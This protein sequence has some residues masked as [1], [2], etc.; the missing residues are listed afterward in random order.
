MLDLG[1]LSKVAVKQERVI[2][3]VG[4]QRPSPGRLS[5]EVHAGF[6]ERTRVV[7]GAGGSVS[8]RGGYY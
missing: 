2:L 1:F 7:G 6:G 8:G 5:Q 3:A 4:T